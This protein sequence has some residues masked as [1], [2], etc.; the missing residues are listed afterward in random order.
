MKRLRIK[1][2]W[3]TKL[4]VNHILTYFNM[5]LLQATCDPGGFGV[6]YPWQRGV[7][8]VMNRPK[9]VEANAELAPEL[10]MRV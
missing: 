8:V 10:L 1:R 6:V 9:G 2:R 5:F 7:E 3:G 4:F